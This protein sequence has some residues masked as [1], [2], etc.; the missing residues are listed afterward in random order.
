MEEVACAHTNRVPK[1]R[2]REL[3]TLNGPAIIDATGELHVT[4]AIRDSPADTT[5]VLDLT[6]EAAKPLLLRH[7][8]RTFPLRRIMRKN[9]QTWDYLGR[10]RCA[11]RLAQTVKNPGGAWVCSMEPRRLELLTPCMP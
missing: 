10:T 6:S 7:M 5:A 2:A 4:V 8:R 1:P 9:E 3:G 11:D